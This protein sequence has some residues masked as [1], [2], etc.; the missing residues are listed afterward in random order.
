MLNELDPGFRRDDDLVRSQAKAPGFASL[1]PGTGHSAG[2]VQPK[3]LNATQD[4]YSP[5][6][7]TTNDRQLRALSRLS[8]IA[9]YWGD[10]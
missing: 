6:P 4:G 3:P 5:K 8:L 9:E 10:S 2:S 7:S 1:Y